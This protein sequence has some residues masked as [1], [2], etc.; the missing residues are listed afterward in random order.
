MFPVLTSLDVDHWGTT[1]NYSVDPS[2]LRRLKGTTDFFNTNVPFAVEELAKR[3]HYVTLPC[4]KFPRI[5]QAF[6]DKSFRTG[7]FPNVSKTK[8]PEYS[9]TA[10]SKSTFF[11]TCATTNHYMLDM[12]AFHRYNKMG[13][14]D[15]GKSGSQ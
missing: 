12:K 14:I 7:K 1:G 11:S 9:E 6:R 5:Q 3:T 15:H 8:I 13:R 2:A 4:D 10:S